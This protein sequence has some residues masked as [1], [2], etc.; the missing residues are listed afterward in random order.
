MRFAALVEKTWCPWWHKVHMN[1]LENFQARYRSTHGWVELAPTVPTSSSHRS[2][3]VVN[4]ER[5]KMFFCYSPVY[6]DGDIDLSVAANRILWGKTMN[7][8][9]TCIAPDYI[10]CTKETQ[11]LYPPSLKF[12][13]G[14]FHFVFWWLTIN[15]E[16]MGILKWPNHASYL[17]L[18]LN[19]SWGKQTLHIDV[20]EIFYYQTLLWQ[21]GEIFL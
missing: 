13:N 19:I 4:I 7:A 16:V 1:Q 12:Y 17:P 3:T 8:G 15:S 18:L 6:V 20:C 2:S 14:P 9:Q 21:I 10:M 11:V 5:V